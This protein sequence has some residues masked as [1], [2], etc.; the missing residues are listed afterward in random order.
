MGNIV[1]TSHDSCFV[2]AALACTSL[3][4]A[5]FALSSF[6]WS[7]PHRSSPPLARARSISAPSFAVKPRFLRILTK[8]D[9]LGY[10]PAQYR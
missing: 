10:D 7:A 6:A 2:F 3:A 9:G 4:G 1:I 8:L 5:S